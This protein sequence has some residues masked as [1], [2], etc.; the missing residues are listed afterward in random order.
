M[1]L[2]ESGAPPVGAYTGG[3]LILYG[4]IDD[5]HWKDV[6]FP[7]EPETGLLV[8]FRSRVVHEVTAVTAGC[9]LSVV[10]WFY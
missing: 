2:N 10:N 7:V 8:A 4:L 9:R 5:P 1:F 3:Q 6:G